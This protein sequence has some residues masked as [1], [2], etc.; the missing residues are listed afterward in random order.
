MSKKKG[1]FITF[2]GIEGS[3]KSTHCKNAACYLKKKGYTVKLIR[4]PG[5]TL[6]GEKVRRL[7]LDK[8]HTAMSVEAELL[9]YNAARVQLIQ[10]VILPVL[11]KGIT[12]VCDRFYDSTVAYQ[13][14]GGGLDQKIVHTVNTF[15]ACGIKPD[16]T[17]L[18]DSDVSRGLKRAGRGDRME[19]KSLAFHKRV[20]RGFLALAKKHPRRF[21]VVKEMPIEK[22]RMIIERK[23]DIAYR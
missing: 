18:L 9:L 17:F 15:A 19:L 2:E 10:E 20:R 6:I 21:V 11:K 22:G 4:E 16:M 12:V 5:G 14:F 23:L 8:K 3:G 1:K 13:C 7:L